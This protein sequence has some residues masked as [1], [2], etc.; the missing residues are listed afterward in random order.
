MPGSWLV[1]GLGNPGEQ[2]ASTPHNLGF[3]VIDRLALRHGIRVE[4]PEA[5]SLAGVGRIGDSEVLLAKP[6][7]FMNL[8]GVSVKSLIGKHSIPPGNL[9]AVYDDLDISWMDV[10]IR[11][12][13]SAGGHNGVKSLIEHLGTNEFSRLRLGIHPD[14]TVR[15]A[16][17]FVL[18]P[19]RKTQLGEVDE[20][21][22]YASQAVESIL[23]E[24]VEKSMTKFNRRAQG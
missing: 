16:A 20:L 1:V 14:H 7:T 12:Q 6:Q 11:P 9:V 4:R 3:L 21:L 18:S 23:A 17:E 15:D 10:R 24:G 2:Y 13:G 8:S 22:D 5:K 19:F